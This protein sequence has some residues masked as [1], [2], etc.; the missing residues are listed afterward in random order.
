MRFDKDRAEVAALAGIPS[1]GI[2]GFQ[3][4]KRPEMTKLSPYEH[5][6]GPYDSREEIDRLFVRQDE[7]EHPFS[8]VHRIKLILE[9]IE[10]R[11]YGAGLRWH[12]LLQQKKL[13][14]FFPLHDNP[15]RDALAKKWIPGGC[16]IRMF[17]NQPNMLI[18]EYFGEKIGLYF[19]FL[20]HYSAWLFI[21]GILGII[22][23]FDVSIQGDA[24]T[25]TS[26]IFCIFVSFWS[27]LMLEYWKRKQATTA[28]EWGT[29][30]F[31]LQER[32]RAEFE[33]EVIKSY[34]N[35][36]E[37]IFFPPSKRRNRIATSFLILFVLIIIVIGAVAIIYAVKHW[38]RFSSKIDFL[39]AN[40]ASV[41]SILNSIQIQVF[42]IIYG[43]LSVKMTEYE[44]HRTDTSFEDMLIAKTFLFQ[45]VNSYSSFYY[46]AFFKKYV[47]G[48][49]YG[50]YCMNDLAFSLGFILIYYLLSSYIFGVAIPNYQSKKR[51]EQEM[52]G[53]VKNM[54]LTQPEF[55]YTK[56]PFDKL[57]GTLSDYAALCVQFGYVTL[58]VPA[59]PIA[60]ALAWFNNYVQAGV[61]AEKL[62]HVCQRAVP[63][64]AQ[65]IGTWQKILT[66][67]AVIAV[68]TN[69][70]LVA[71]TSGFLQREGYSTT[72]AMWVFIVSQYIVFLIM[73]WFSFVV[74]DVPQD[75][76]IQMERSNF[77]VSKLIGHLPD[78][79]DVDESLV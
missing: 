24:G 72:S 10:H 49:D 1:K 48:C 56:E 38:L 4:Q 78:D 40:A 64:G 30:D 60:P 53:P 68:V 61:N 19:V 77:I 28:M 55:E 33:G 22:V 8:S 66:I 35:G 21:L 6:Y 39:E 14:A 71:F 9:L 27:V 12:Y 50:E 31:E 3:I 2:K 51:K 58:F 79:N 47:E 7:L 74:E 43:L 42:N 17:K 52:K 75:V 16:H 41:A 76:Q 23:Q 32:E 34:I 29:T 15:K 59:F 54:S 37:M 70:G 18:K 67:L 57:M 69:A 62:L 63:A 44:N 13:K 20:A 5:I 25:V 65:D 45:F 11:L 36:Q 46:T 26:L 73:G